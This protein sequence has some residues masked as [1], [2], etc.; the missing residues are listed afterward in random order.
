M[1]VAIILKKGVQRLV[2][3]REVK[4]KMADWLDGLLPERQ[5]EFQVHLDSCNSC[6]RRVQET[7]QVVHALSKLKQPVAA[8][9]PEFTAKVMNYLK[10]ECLQKEEKISGQ[11]HLLRIPLRSLALA[12]SILFLFGINSI[13]LS[14]HGVGGLIGRTPVTDSAAGDKEAVANPN[15]IN[16]V[17]QFPPA[18]E[19]IIGE[20]AG[21][22]A[23]L[24]ADLP[25]AHPE[26][27]P[28]AISADLP[29]VQPEALHVAIPAEQPVAAKIA[30][31]QKP[32]AIPREKELPVKMV[33]QG[34]PPQSRTAEELKELAAVPLSL[35]PTQ[36]NIQVPEPHIFLNRRRVTESTVL[37]IHVRQL[38]MASQTLVSNARMQGATPTME[39]TILTHDGRLIRLYQFEVPFTQ[40]NQFLAGATLLGNLITEKQIH[41]DI[42]NEYAKKLAQYEQ[43]VRQRFDAGG[44]E[45]ARLSQTINQLLSQMSALDRN[46]RT[47]QNVTVWLES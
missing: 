18:R 10:T 32:L 30:E 8:P 37:K 27:L 14:S 13:L 21:D 44:E 34:S 33:R 3:C 43:A 15:E 19:D 35:L 29:P 39:D 24:P 2:R 11:R 16:Q 28:V 17:P 20:P 31:R 23:N 40:T 36:V 46:S 6:Y 45:E 7:K 25:P 22:S 5:R 42:T 9:P 1:N 12:A 47:T 4:G 41:T 26:V 38:A